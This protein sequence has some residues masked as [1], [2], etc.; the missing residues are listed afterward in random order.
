[1]RQTLR[2]F[3]LVMTLIA[4]TALFSSA[5]NSLSWTGC[6]DALWG[7]YNESPYPVV[8]S[9]VESEDGEVAGEYW[10]ENYL[11]EPTLG[12]IKGSN[13]EGVLIGSYQEGEYSGLIEFV[14]GEEGETFDGIWH[15]FG[16]EAGYWTGGRK[17]CPSWTGSWETVWAY[18][19]EEPYEVIITFIQDEQGN[20]HGEY[21]YETYLG[22]IA[23]GTIQ[24]TVTATALDGEYTEGEYTDILSF[25][26]SPDGM[27]FKGTWHEFDHEAGY[28][29]GERLE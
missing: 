14:L 23:Y 25:R 1:M 15:E 3:L 22:E 12:T 10:Y 26:M 2:S 20:V 8:M 17:E 27:S 21:Q 28:W 6:W 7:Y 5:A 16:A 4:S 18:Y 11:G 13:E 19:D 29:N 24:G 9:F